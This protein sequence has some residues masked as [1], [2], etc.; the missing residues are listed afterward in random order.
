MQSICL[1][2]KD[3]TKGRAHTVFILIMNISNRKATFSNSNSPNYYNFGTQLH[4][5]LL[6]NIINMI[7]KFILWK[8]K[9][10]RIAI[11]YKSIRLDN[12]T[13]EE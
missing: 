7:D 1:F 13:Q 3:S 4:E 11:Y 2:V 9:K 5:L 10:V 8:I 12:F 6:Y